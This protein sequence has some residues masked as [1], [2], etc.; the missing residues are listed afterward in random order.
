MKFHE[1]N[2]TKK[3]NSPQAKW[4]HRSIV[5]KILDFIF[6]VTQA[7]HWV[8]HA[9][10]ISEVKLAKLKVDHITSK[11]LKSEKVCISKNFVTRRI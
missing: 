9:G 4:L 1:A 10:R 7:K 2:L 11:T 3:Q 8:R 5:K 6:I